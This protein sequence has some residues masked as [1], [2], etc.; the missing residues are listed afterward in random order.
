MLD[1]NKWLAARHGLDQELVDLPKTKRVPTR[2]LALR[3][4]ERVRH[5]AEELGSA[6]E[7]EGIEDLLDRGNGAV[8]ADRGLPGQPRPPRGRERDLEKT[9]A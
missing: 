2:E 4:L 8:A 5:H 6:D 9:G 7:L 1:E 3:V